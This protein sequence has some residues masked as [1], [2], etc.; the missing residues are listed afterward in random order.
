LHGICSAGPSGFGRVERAGFFLVID[1]LYDTLDRRIDVW[2]EVK[3]RKTVKLDKNQKV[4]KGLFI[5]RLL[6]G[7]DIASAL[8][9]LHKLQVIFRDLKPDNVGFDFEG[10]VK[11]FDFGLAKELDYMQK[12]D[13]G[14][15]NMSGGT[16]SRRFMAPEVAL[17][18]PYHLSAD[19]YSFSILLWELLTLDKAFARMSVDEHKERVVKSNERPELDPEWSDSLTVLLESCWKRSPFQRPTARDAYKTLRQEI[20]NVIVE[21]FPKQAASCAEED[22]RRA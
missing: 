10:R 7:Q 5:Q 13:S 18:E 16:G 1:R 12:Q 22:R 9:H 2:K 3:K 14:L 17:S 20:Q 8:R 6:V 21:S 15:Y 19:M 11:L 4:L